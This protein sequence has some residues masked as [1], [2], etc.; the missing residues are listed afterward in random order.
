MSKPTGMRAFL[1]VWAGQVASLLGTA[2]SQ[3]ALTIWAYQ[4]TGSAT[5]LA[6][7]SFFSFGPGVIFGPIAGAL[8]DRWNRKLV[9]MLSDL[10]AGICTIAIFI[11]YSTGNLQIWHLY[12]AGVITGIFGAFQWPA[13]SAAIST[14]LPRAQYGRANGLLSLAESVSG[15]FAPIFATGLLALVGLSGVLLFDI[16][17]FTVAVSALLVVHIPQPEISEAGTA[18]KGSLIQES[19]YGFRYI[20]RRPSLLGLQV[21]FLGINLTGNVAGTIQA[22]MLLARTG[23]DEAVLATVQSVTAA[24]SVLGGLL[25]STWGGPKRRV[26]GVLLGMIL[27]SVLGEMFMGVGRTVVSWSAA[28]FLFGMIMPFVNGSNQAIWQ[29]K[30]PPDLQGRVF[31]ARRMIAQITAPIAML[32]AGPLA[33]QVFEPAMQA[34]GSLAPVFGGLVGTGAGAGMGLMLVIFGAL[35]ALVGLAGY[36]FR[37]VRDAEDLLPDHGASASQAA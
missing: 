14:M 35:G 8:V 17:S 30:V 12:V 4:I 19:A 32:I 24:G 10:G 5:A 3:F 6:L 22:P 20:L 29:A 7:V 21:T 31:A 2:M 23:S 11:L 13:Y 16:I 1:V 27:T 25:L 28:G 9:M 37:V 33:D 26:H 15:V 36:A 18:G 34:G